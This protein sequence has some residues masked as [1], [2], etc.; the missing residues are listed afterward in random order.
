MAALRFSEMSIFTYSGNKIR[1]DLNV[2]VQIECNCPDL[3][4]IV[5][6]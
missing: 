6:T 2:I 5:Q 1:K 3:N 4:V